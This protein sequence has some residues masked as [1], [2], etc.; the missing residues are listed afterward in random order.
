MKRFAAI[1]SHHDGEHEANIK[2]A[3]GDKHTKAQRDEFLRTLKAQIVKVMQ[4]AAQ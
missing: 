3:W 1:I 2:I 4:G